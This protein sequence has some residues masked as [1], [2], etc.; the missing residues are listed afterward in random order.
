MLRRGTNVNN[1]STYTGIFR[2]GSKSRFAFW[3][4]LTARPPCCVIDPVEWMT[5]TASPLFGVVPLAVNEYTP[6]HV[7]TCPEKPCVPL[8]K[9][10]ARTLYFCSHVACAL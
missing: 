6:F 8:G 2:R 4:T 1:S 10:V 5:L 3:L 7:Y 9:K